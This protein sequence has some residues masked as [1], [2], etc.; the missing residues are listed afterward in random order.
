MAADAGVDFALPRLRLLA[1]GDAFT[2]GVFFCAAGFSADARL[3]LRDVAG[4]LAGV[5]AAEAAGVIF[6]GARLRLREAGG[7]LAAS[8]EVEGSDLLA[9]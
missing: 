5:A 2:A 9:A 8:E 6:L 3:R 1:A 7:V 4:D